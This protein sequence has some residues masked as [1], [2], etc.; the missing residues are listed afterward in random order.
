LPDENETVWKRLEPHLDLAVA[1]LSELDRQAVLLRFYQQKPFVEV[2]RQLGLGEEAAKKR[3]SRAMQKL[4]DFLI[5]RSVAVGGTTLVGLL[6]GQVVQA[7]PAGLAASVL[8]TTAMQISATGVLPHLAR[9]TLNAW[10][11]TQF[12]IATAV[13]ASLCGL[14]WLCF[15]TVPHSPINQNA[16]LEPESVRTAGDQPTTAAAAASIAPANPE[17]RNIHFRVLAKDSD[18]PIGGAPL[19]VNIVSPE[20]GWKQRF[21]LSTDENGSADIPYPRETMRLDVGVVASGCRCAQPA[22]RCLTLVLLGLACWP[23]SSFSHSSSFT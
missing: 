17:T 3:V 5:R 15:V 19:A 4:R 11:W 22:L 21:D 14:V 20:G 16:T 8:K 2:G 23:F 6:A 1:S 9:E 10:R 7:A 13:T 12:K 18:Q